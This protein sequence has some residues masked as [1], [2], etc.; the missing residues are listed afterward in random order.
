MLVKAKLFALTILL[1]CFHADGVTMSK[2]KWG[3][4][5]F[6]PLTFKSESGDITGDLAELTKQ[7]L[8][9]AGVKYEAIEYPNRRIYSLL[10]EGKIDFG[11][12]TR[13][14]I[15]NPND[16][17]ISQFAVSQIELRA[18][19]VGQKTE[20]KTPEDLIGQRVILLSAYT[21]GGLRAFFNDPANKVTVVANMEQHD[22]AFEALN[23][24]RGD[25]VL[26]Y[27]G[28]SRLALNDLTIDNLQSSVLSK[29]DVYFIIHKSV[30]DAKAIM[31]SLDAHYLS[32]HRHSQIPPCGP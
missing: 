27:T 4:A 19:W 14:F 16:F 3:Y 12:F 29:L 2:V 30:N 5:H 15:S 9:A 23:L 8:L 20:I 10:N 6:P 17:I 13:S 32:T 7:S 11:V 26:D 31:Q 22:R 25:Y 24:G 28:P 18:Y 21:Y 1:I